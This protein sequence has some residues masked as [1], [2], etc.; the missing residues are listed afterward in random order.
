MFLRRGG[1]IVLRP[2]G[3]GLHSSP[4]R[5]APAVHSFPQVPQAGNLA[6]A[7]LQR[8]DRVVM[9]LCHARG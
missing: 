4:E 3:Q 6:P 2:D 7:R 8:M 1:A 9:G 5:R